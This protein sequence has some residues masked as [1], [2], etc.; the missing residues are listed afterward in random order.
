VRRFDGEYR[1]FLFRAEP[2][3][4]DCGNIIR[5]YGTN[6]DI[7]ERKRVESLL[8]AEKRTFEMIAGGARLA[9]ILENLCNTIDAQVPNLISTVMLMDTD[10]MRLWPGAGPRLPKGWVDAIAP[11]MIGPCVRSCG[12]AAFR[13][14]RVIASD[15]ATKPFMG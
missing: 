6:T 11:V 13:R 8:A 2:L 12:T 7:E 4:D 10:G 3:R 1:W 9:D 14:Q 15:I 5:W